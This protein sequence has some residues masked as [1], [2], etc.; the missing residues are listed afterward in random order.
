MD[1]SLPKTQFSVSAW[2]INVIVLF[3][4]GVVG[5]IFILGLK[6]LPDYF[7]PII[8]VA[9]LVTGMILYIYEHFTSTLVFLF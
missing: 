4:I 3:L 1:K 2:I 9:M 6:Y 5:L 7:G 8:L